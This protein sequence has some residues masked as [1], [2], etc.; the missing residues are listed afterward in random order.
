MRAAVST[1][2]LMLLWQMPAGAAAVRDASGR[3][4]SVDDPSRIVS[5]GGA[6]TEI[7]Y[8]L[9]RS[10][11]LV[12]VDTTSLFPPEALKSKP[13][14]GYFRQLSPEGV[15]GLAPSVILAVEGSGP[16]EAVAVLR[17]ASIPLVSIPD[18][19]DG[20]GIVEKI[21]MIAKAI[22]ADREGECL[23]R[24][25]TNDLSALASL[26][27][28]IKAP[29]RVLFILS[30]MNGRP[31]V[32]GRG[33]AADGLIRMAGA[34][35]AFDNFEG[36]KI[37]N[38]EAVLAAAPDAVIGMKRAGLDLDAS[39]VFAHAAFRETPAAKKGRFFAMDGLYMLGFG[40]RTARAARDLSRSLY[41]EITFAELPSEAR[42][43]AGKPCRN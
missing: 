10:D 19:F 34:V 38:D 41:P 20:E 7:L 31:M 1:A 39:S 42:K 37:V 9:G 18:K 43:D 17:S 22:D 28:G 6:V 36:Y 16:K 23:S 25:V 14:V 4:I 26:R 24:L 33:T 12:A 21:K 29:V 15:I 5:I 8:A 27:S 11:R 32:A 30:F 35:N 13:N 2:L 3:T 40:P